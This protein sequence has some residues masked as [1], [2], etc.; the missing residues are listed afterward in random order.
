MQTPFR[1]FTK[2]CW[3]VDTFGVSE[4]STKS[5]QDARRDLLNAYIRAHFGSVNAFA[6]ALG[7]KQPQL[8]ET[9]KGSRSFGE[10]LAR[11]LEAEVSALRESVQWRH[12]PALNFDSAAD[13][14]SARVRQLI[15]YFDSLPSEQAQDELLDYAR[16]KSTKSGE[17]P[18]A[19]QVGRESPALGLGR[20]QPRQTPAPKKRRRA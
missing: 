1:D 9:L 10:K 12:L 18:A 11:A 13:S 19:T 5:V 6:N 14:T 16:F 7:R 20:L 4:E 17:E 2:R 8:N 15:E 3:L